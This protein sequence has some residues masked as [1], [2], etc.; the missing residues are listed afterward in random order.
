V[1]VK[2]CAQILQPHAGLLRDS[3]YPHLHDDHYTNICS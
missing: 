3:P 2:G 1:L